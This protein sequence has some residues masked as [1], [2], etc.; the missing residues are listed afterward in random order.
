MPAKDWIEADWPVPPKVRTLVT[1]RAGGV[2]QGPYASLNL[3][4]HVGDAP[5][6][7]T[8][9]RA[10]L[11]D[12][13]PAE[14]AWLNQVHGVAVADAASAGAIPPDA[15]ASFARAPGAVC[16]VMTAD[17][18]PVLLCEE[19]GQA[20]AAAHAG[21]RGLCDGVIEATVAAMGLP[22]TRLMAWLGP[23]IGPDAFEVGAEVR[24]AFVE[25]DA[26]AA[27][28]F[29]EIDHGKYLADIYALARLRLEKL[30]VSRI[31]GGDF[32]TVIDR[33]R[34]FSYRRDRITGRMASLIWLEA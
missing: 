7:V 8:A 12:E 21:W 2:S 29:V 1:T 20:V 33:E 17:C 15:D 9:N 18:L 26:A 19:Q 3:G 24:Q 30:G 4:A 31:H 23:A 14:P 5:E 34:F 10:L 16:V 22:P 11:R 25:K 28:A 27:A 13:L 32:C 6:A